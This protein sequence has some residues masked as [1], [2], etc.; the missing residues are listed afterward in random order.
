MSTKGE[1]GLRLQTRL[2]SFT[3]RMQ[4]KAEGFYLDLPALA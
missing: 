1:A 2:A 3:Q 4:P